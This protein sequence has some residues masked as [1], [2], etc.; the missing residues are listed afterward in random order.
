M[1]VWDTTTPLG[2]ESKSLGDDRIREFKEAVQ[3]AL[4]SGAASGVESV[5]PGPDPSTA[6]VHRYRGLKGAS[7]DRPAAGNYGLF[8]NETTNTLQRDNGSSWVDIATL[9]PAGTVMVFYQAAAPVGWTKLTTQNDKALR[10]VSG[11]GGVDGG[12]LSMSGGV[13]HSHT[14]NSHTH[15]LGSHTH[16][17][18]NHTHRLAD[19]T[20]V[21]LTNPTISPSTAAVGV[22]GS[23]AAD[24]TMDYYSQ[25]GG[26]AGGVQRKLSTTDSGGSGTSGAASGNTGGATPGTDT[27][28]PVL[29]YID[30]IICSKD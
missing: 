18:P 30:I 8:A 1:S 20:R 10:V 22:S 19:G 14:V 23:A 3:D 9:I 7:V 5:F 12:S 17:T 4:R 27:Q 2:S 26:G 13:S 16:T 28:A 21:I 29:A 25:V 15:D 24:G 11:S 6:P